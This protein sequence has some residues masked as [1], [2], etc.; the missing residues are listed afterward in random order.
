M[1]HTYAYFTKV[2]GYASMNEY[3]VALA[4]TTCVGIFPSGSA[5]ARLNI[6]DLSALALERTQ[7]ARQAVTV[8][9]ALAEQYGYNDNAEVGCRA[10]T[11][12]SYIW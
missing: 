8:M 3:Q 12:R 9:G 10:T 5:A 11:W 6:V 7:S 4:E 1:S 2:G